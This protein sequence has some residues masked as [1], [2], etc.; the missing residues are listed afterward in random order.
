MI[1]E[2]FHYA[3]NTGL[4]TKIKDGVGMHEAEIGARFKSVLVLAI[5]YKL[6]AESVS[7]GLHERVFSTGRVHLPL[8]TT[9]RC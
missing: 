1:A 8:A 3:T 6:I 9:I 2:L 5:G 4:A 7:K